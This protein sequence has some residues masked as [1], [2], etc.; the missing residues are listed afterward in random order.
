[1]ET[2]SKSLEYVIYSSLACI[3]M[4]AVIIRPLVER[5]Y[6]LVSR[7]G[8]TYRNLNPS[9]RTS[10]WNVNDLEVR[11]ERMLR[12]LF[13]TVSSNASK[14]EYEDTYQY[15][16]CMALVYFP[17]ALMKKLTNDAASGVAYPFDMAAL[18]LTEMAR[19]EPSFNKILR[20]IG[21][22]KHGSSLEMDLHTAL[23]YASSG[24]NPIIE[25]DLNFRKREAAIPSRDWM[26][27]SDWWVDDFD[28]EGEETC[29]GAI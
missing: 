2:I 27:G 24:I 4:Y 11:T 9:R 17:R 22:G 5:R 21:F 25:M 6:R 18:L 28:D 14:Y 7:L 13:N 19:I 1:M 26:D 29:G 20:S 8:H 15:D 12:Y 23:S 16:K 10:P 3:V